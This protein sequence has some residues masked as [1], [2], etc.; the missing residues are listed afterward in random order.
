MTRALLRV[1]IV[2]MGVGL[3]GI[4]WAQA[5]HPNPW[6]VG[7][8]VPAAPKEPPPPGV[9]DLKWDDLLPRDWNPRRLLNE[10]GLGKLK[11]NDPRADEI[12]AKIRAEYDRAPVV[13]ELDGAR[14]RLAGF[15]VMLEGTPK[16]I[17]EFLLVPYFG[18]CIHVPPPPANQIVH[19]FPQQPVPESLSSEA[20]WVTGTVTVTQAHTKH[21]AVGYRIGAAQVE[22]YRR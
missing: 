1:V 5:P 2:A 12:L 10:M 16:G 20:V 18:A 4:A 19:V 21:G 6:A 17:T 13:K 22:K 11:D 14:V 8:Q 15:A 9:R 3:V 7:D